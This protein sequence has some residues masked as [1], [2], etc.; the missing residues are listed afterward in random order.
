LDSVE[1]INSASKPKAH[2]GM[3]AFLLVV[4]VGSLVALLSCQPNTR[5]RPYGYL[6]LG[7]ISKFLA[8]E[9]YLPEDRLLIR[10]DAGGLSA[11]STE[12]TRDLSP[13]E[14]R[15]EGNEKFWAS[16]FSK[17]TYEYGGD[18]RTGPT[19]RPLP[20]Y[21][22]RFEAGK[23]GG[24]VDTLYAVIGSKKGKAWRLPFPEIPVQN[25]DSVNAP[26]DTKDTHQ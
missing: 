1:E 18:I 9:T 12:C 13:L 7:P 2:R 25:A 15:V 17:S 5:E 4:L 22:L 23:Y 14:L 26:P 8:E 6:R 19:I 3:A 11:M 10:H 16:R 24:P 21:E 20:Y